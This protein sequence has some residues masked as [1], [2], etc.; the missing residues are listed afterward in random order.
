M[1]P[2]VDFEPESFAAVHCAR[3]LHFLRG[4][5]IEASLAKMFHWLEPHGWLFVTVDTPYTGIWRAAGPRYEAARRAGEAWP[6]L[7]EDFARFLPPGTDPAGQP[8]FIHPLDPD[9][10]ERVCR[11][12]G[13]A[14][15]RAGFYGRTGQPADSQAGRAHAGVIATKP[16]THL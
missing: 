5:D 10:L 16:G 7:I 15:E 14:I 2:D 11:T 8:E 1:L 6:G 12:V 13:F 4:P 3:T 9:I